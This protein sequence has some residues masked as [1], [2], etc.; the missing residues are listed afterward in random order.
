MRCRFVASY[1][2]SNFYKLRCCL[3]W[4]LENIS[5]LLKFESTKLVIN[6]KPWKLNPRLVRRILWISPEWDHEIAGK[7]KTSEPDS[8]WGRASAPQSR[9]WRAAAMHHRAGGPHPTPSRTILFGNNDLLAPHS[10]NMRNWKR[11][12]HQHHD[13][14]KRMSTG[15]RVSVRYKRIRKIPVHTA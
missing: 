10:H 4:V 3:Y 2:S 14:D 15:L 13:F 6:P 9:P 8:N 5:L 7:C 1:N 11:L 12:H